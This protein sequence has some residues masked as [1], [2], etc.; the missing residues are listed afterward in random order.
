[1][2]TTGNGHNSTYSMFR[3][4]F[5]P[6]CDQE[7]S[8]GPWAAHSF[9]AFRRKHWSM[10]DKKELSEPWGD[11]LQSHNWENRWKYSLC[12]QILLRTKCCM[13]SSCVPCP[14]PQTHRVICC[15][16]V[17]GQ[18]QVQMT[19]GNVDFGDCLGYIAAPTG[20]TILEIKYIKSKRK[21][22]LR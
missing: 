6:R 5:P 13:S 20:W 15:Q 16:P 4:A 1:M 11:M 22:M 18:A 12:G 17:F 7:F 8:Q 10:T 14:A 21:T 9:P 3:K 2:N 19:Q